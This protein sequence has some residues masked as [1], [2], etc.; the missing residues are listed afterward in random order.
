MGS[1][2]TI[3][4]S[5]AYVTHVWGHNLRQPRTTLIEMELEGGFTYIKPKGVSIELFPFD[6][7]LH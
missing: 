1:G 5:R 2:S 7:V 6:S 3:V 4:H